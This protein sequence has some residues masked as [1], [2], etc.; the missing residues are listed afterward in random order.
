[1]VHS[2][3]DSQTFFV[4]KSL[5]SFWPAMLHH[6]EHQ[7]PVMGHEWRRSL[8]HGPG[9]KLDARQPTYTLSFSLPRFLVSWSL[10]PQ[11]SSEC[12]LFHLS[13][14]HSPQHTH[15]N[16]GVIIYPVLL[17]APQCPGQAHGQARSG[18]PEL[19]PMFV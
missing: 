16:W 4:L 18:W 3:V 1:M 5:L 15:R 6:S 11:P 7:A 9:G 17:V 2:A 14:R 19:P 12:I 10:S 8:S 13:R